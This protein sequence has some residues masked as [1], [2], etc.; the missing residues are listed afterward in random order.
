VGESDDATGQSCRLG[1]L[2]RGLRQRSGMTPDELHPARH[3][4]TGQYASM[5][6][7]I[8]GGAESRVQDAWATKATEAG[9][10]LGGNGVNSSVTG[11]S[12]E[13]S[14]WRSQKTHQGPGSMPAGS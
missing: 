14:M 9:S 1:Y 7:R 11:S 4:P 13:V 3:D 2:A 10:S 8:E 6:R 12:P 5:Y